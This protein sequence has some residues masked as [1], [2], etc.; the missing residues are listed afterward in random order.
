MGRLSAWLWV[1]S[2]GVGLL[3]AV[4]CPRPPADSGSE[5]L[6]ILC[7]G[8]FRPPMERIAKEFQE[9]TGIPVILDFGQSED[10]LPKVKNHAAGDIFV[11][12]DPYI[13]FTREN[14][15]LGR[16]VHVGYVAPALV[17]KKG[18]PLGIKSIEDLAKP[19]VRVVLMNPQ[20]ATCGKMTF[21]LLEKKGIKDKVL[22][23]VGNALK[24][25]HADVASMIKL[26]HRDAGIMW[27]GMAYNWRDD[28]EIVPTPYEYDEEIRVCIMGLSY[29]KKTELV[30]KLLQFAEK[31]GK[32]IFEE[33][34]YKKIEPPGKQVPDSEQPGGDKGDKKESAPGSTAPDQQPTGSAQQD[35]P[36]AATQQSQQAA[37]QG[38]S[39]GEQTGSTTAQQ[40]ASSDAAER[41]QDGRQLLLYCGAGIRPPVAEIV[42]LFREKHGVTVQCDFAGSEVLLNKAKLSRR[43]D[44]FMPGDQYYV[45]QAQRAGLIAST[46]VVAY[47]VPVILVQR[48]NP[49]NIQSL[50]DLSRPDL[51]IGLGDA[52]ACAIGRLCS[53]LLANNGIDEQQLPVVYRSVTVHDLGN[54]IKLKSLDAVI[55]WD[56]V[57]AYYS[58]EG[59]VVRIPLEQN[60]IATIA[61]GILKSSED[62]QLAAKLVD[63][64][65]SPIGKEI[66]AKHRYTVEDPRLSLPQ[67]SAF[68]PPG[69]KLCRNFRL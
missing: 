20:Y 25:E 27:N 59:E 58:R 60:V 31:R 24:R 8:S 17:V 62:P 64:L 15:A 41:R 3:C 36:Q 23:N 13:D 12:H 65:T 47:F 7:G 28:I 10:L 22:E 46:R 4:G 42:E 55:V 16:F 37:G 18:N 50:A 51:K 2:V 48:G 32:E 26:D 44:L 34:G 6:H 33:M 40:Q 39:S 38:G 5:G 29:S 54:Q 63:L 11:S 1:A 43:G 14:K 30:E 21:K 67:T 19:G 35:S 49:K 61:V 66:F 68:L 9:Q 52:R 69:G 53:Q 45:A 56:A 57:A